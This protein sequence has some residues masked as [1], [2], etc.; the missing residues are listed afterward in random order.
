MPKQVYIQDTV[1]LI[2]KL[3][4]R[5]FKI[6]IIIPIGDFSATSGNIK[7][8]VSCVS[9]DKHFLTKLDLTLMDKMNFASSMRLCNPRIWKLL[10]Q[11]VPFSDGTQVYLK[12]MY[13]IHCTVFF[14]NET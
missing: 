7:S 11:K 4:N 3:K 12:I 8:L 10:K 2:N 13:Y 5:L 6:S 1:H 9:K 14:I